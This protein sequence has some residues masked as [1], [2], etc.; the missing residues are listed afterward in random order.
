MFKI[1]ADDDFV[2]NALIWGSPVNIK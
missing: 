1:A 2:E